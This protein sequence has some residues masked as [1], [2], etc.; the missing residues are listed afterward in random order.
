MIGNF[1]FRNK[2]EETVG[3]HLIYRYG[4]KKDHKNTS[5][6]MGDFSK[7]DMKN[8]KIWLNYFSDK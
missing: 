8:I 2:I 6:G 4:A 3:K 5:F 7:M 1:F